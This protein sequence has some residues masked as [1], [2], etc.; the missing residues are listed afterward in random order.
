MSLAILFGLLAIAHAI[1][2]EVQMASDN[3]TLIVVAFAIL[4]DTTR[5][6]KET[7]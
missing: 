2:P 6:F 3:V 7:K 4:H 1:N 5:L